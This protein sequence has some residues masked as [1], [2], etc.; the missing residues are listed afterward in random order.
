MTLETRRAWSSGPT[1]GVVVLAGLLGALLW[2]VP[3][4]GSAGFGDVRND[5]FFT[6][7]VQWMVDE[8]I[9]TG[10]SEGCFSPRL[11]VTRGEAAAFMWRMEGEPAARSS[12]GFT[13]VR[14]SWQHDAVAWMVEERITTGTAPGRFSPDATL[15]R[16][17]LA[18]LLHRLEGLPAGGSHGF[19]DVYAAWQQD[20]VAW[21]VRASITTG[22]GPGR[23]SPDAAVTRG[24]LATFF[25]RYK[26][27]PAVEVDPSSP[28]CGGSTFDGDTFFV[29]VN[30]PNASNSNPG[31]ETRPWRTIVHAAATA[32]RGDRI[33]IKQGTYGHG[34]IK[35]RSSGLTISAYPGHERRVVI[36][37]DGLISHG[38]SDL[39]I[40]GLKFINSDEHA[41]RVVG[42]NARNIII[43]NNHTYNSYNSGISIR[44]V[45]GN[46]DPGN[47][48]NMRNVVVRDNLVELGT[49][50][51]NG[52]II[53]VGSGVINIDVAFNE[54][55]VG[56]PTGVGGDEGISFKEGV[57]DS[58]IY[59]NVI[60]DL[61]DKGIHIDG[62]ENIH[63]AL[64]TN[65]EIFDN[66]IYDLPSHGMWVTTEGRGDVDGVHIHD[67]IVFDVAKNGI[68]VYEHPDGARDGGTVRNVLIEHN[69]TWNTGER[70]GTGGIRVDHPSAPGVVIRDNI[71]WGG[72]SYGIRGDV[73]TTISGRNLCPEASLCNVTGAPQFVNPPDDFRL[74]ST[75]PAIGAG[76]G[77]SNLGAR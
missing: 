57:R 14:K 63:D 45:T 25:W 22:T 5:E 47:Y 52:E 18:A 58:R 76:T 30:H 11:P 75:S 73:G 42:P 74:R 69:T 51:G 27:S 2:A 17:Q 71:A 65:I 8:D 26:G 31:T 61:S 46:A 35:V 49:N 68:L 40:N 4:S 54:V 16:G 34:D 19:D 60:H 20:P 1:L 62:G 48:D 9:T 67:N 37:G 59:G 10:T 6:S 28:P 7:A 53:S 15:T 23:F 21:M 3:A 64:I 72:R 29:D 41:I 70:S 12:H 13:D 77:G 43:S 32:S 56:D 33:Y 44:G 24:Q 66:I 38:H 39:T 36:P 55:R 50:G